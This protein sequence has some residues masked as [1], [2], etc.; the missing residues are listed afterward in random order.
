[1]AV[2]SPEHSNWSQ[3]EQGRSP[4]GKCQ[5]V[6]SCVQE[7]ASPPAV[8]LVNSAGP[9]QCLLHRHRWHSTPCG[10]RSFHAGWETQQTGFI[11]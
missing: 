10:P 9:E 6:V 3:R 5:G 11:F 4:S 2:S 7:K 8:P 1:M